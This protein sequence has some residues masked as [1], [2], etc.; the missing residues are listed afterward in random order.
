[1]EVDNETF[2]GELL[3]ILEHIADASYVTFDLEMSGI[4][5]RPRYTT[6]DRSHDVGKPSLQQQYDEIRDAAQ[7]FQ[8]V[9]VGIT[10]IEED[11]DKGEIFCLQ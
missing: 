11:R 1:M 5:T 8:V 9:Q 10:C 4:T 2:R 6:G 3:P 7:T